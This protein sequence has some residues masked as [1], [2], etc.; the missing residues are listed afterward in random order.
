MYLEK[1]ARRKG[2]EGPYY[3]IFSL[4]YQSGMLYHVMYMHAS[5]LLNVEL[6]KA[7]KYWSKPEERAGHWQGGLLRSCAS[8]PRARGKSIN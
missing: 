7:G 3:E 6:G 1:P 5:S 4:D 8:V 2:F